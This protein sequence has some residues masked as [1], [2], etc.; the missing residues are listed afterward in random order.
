MMSE[1]VVS[2]VKSGLTLAHKMAMVRCFANRILVLFVALIHANS[3]IVF[4]ALILLLVSYYGLQRFR[5]QVADDMLDE[6]G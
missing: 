2:V 1:N 5:L 6:L 3:F 4:E